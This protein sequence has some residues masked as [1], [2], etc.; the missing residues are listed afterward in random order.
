M[1]KKEWIKHF[2]KTQGRKPTATESAEAFSTSGNIKMYIGL[3][4]T[5]LVIVIAA[6]IFL[7]SSNAKKE[8]NQTSSVTTEKTDGQKK[9]DDKEKEA[10]IQKLKEQLKA[11]DAK[12]SESEEL[13]SRLNKETQVPFNTA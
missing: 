5:A 2:E 11:L 12:I 6:S 8:A 10:E 1:N 3:A 4:L 13:V 9:T 7:N